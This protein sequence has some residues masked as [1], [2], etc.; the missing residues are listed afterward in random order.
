MCR[1]PNRVQAQT[2][3]PY[4]LIDGKFAATLASL[5]LTSDI[6]GREARGAEIAA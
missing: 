4:V 2:G 5:K 3:I 6:L 1:W